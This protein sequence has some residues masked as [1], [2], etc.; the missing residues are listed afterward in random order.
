MGIRS[1]R[2]FLSPHIDR[3]LMYKTI[4]LLLVYIRTRYSSVEGKPAASLY[5]ASG[6]RWGESKTHPGEYIMSQVCRGV[7]R[8]RIC[9]S[10][11]R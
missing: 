8:F 4:P 1:S 7:N 10:L 2:K 11:M 5:F 9:V 3:F 6:T